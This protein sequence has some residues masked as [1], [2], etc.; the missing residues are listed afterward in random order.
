MDLYFT[1]L[2]CSMAVRIAL[3]EAEA[4]ARFI[5]VDRTTKR[6]LEDADFLALNP[7]GFVPALRTDS[8]DVLTEVVAILHYVA[9]VFPA[10]ELAP[11][12]SLARAKMHQWLC[13][14]GTELHKA[15]FT[16]LFDPKLPEEAKARAL[17]KCGTTFAYL[18]AHLT[19][20]E[21]LL[22]RFSIADAYLFT[23]LNW[24]V[25]TPI[26]LKTWPAVKAYHAGLKQRPSIARAFSEERALYAA[27]QARHKAA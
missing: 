22:D 5:E 24:C 3:Y 12:D 21:F 15:L 10:V 19:G 2:T 1:P 18:D 9:D 4:P 23:V 20:R 16:S 8:G 17:D 25:A 27:E 26:D 7:L 6:T 11:Q 14:T 13:F